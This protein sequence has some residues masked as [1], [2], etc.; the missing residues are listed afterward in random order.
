MRYFGGTSGHW[1]GWCKPLDRADFG[2]RAGSDLPSWPLTLDELSPH[3]KKALNWCE[4][5]SD[6]FDAADSVENP[7][8][9]LLFGPGMAFTQQL[10]RFSPPTRFG[11][12]YREDIQS[13]ELSRC[14][15]AAS[16]VSLGHKGD[17]IV[18]AR[19]VNLDGD[20]LDIK[21][22]H[23]IL[24]MGGIEN[25]RFL[26]HT[27]DDSGLPFGNHSGLLG[28]CFMEH[29]GFHPGYMIAPAGLRLFQHI[30]NKFR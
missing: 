28:Q 3:Y 19:A 14:F 23:F 20:S 17:R 26:L 4:I 21:A 30:T 12:R 2:R 6:N 7:T 27:R 9:D 13:S 5:G 24:A 29:F 16:L 15:C 8:E 11:T 22:D 1:G 10:F 25:T 18:S